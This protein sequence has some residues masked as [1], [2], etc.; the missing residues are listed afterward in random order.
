M[1]FSKH[2][3]FTGSESSMSKQSATGRKA[4][5]R[6]RRSYFLKNQ[7]LA[8]ANIALQ[9]DV[10][11]LQKSLARSRQQLPSQLKSPRSQVAQLTQGQFISNDIREKLMDNAVLEAELQ[12]VTEGF[13]E[14]NTPGKKIFCKFLSGRILKRYKRLGRFKKI[15]PLK[16]MKTARKFYGDRKSISDYVKKSTSSNSMKIRESVQAF[17]LSETASHYSAGKKCFVKVD[18][19]KVQKRYLNDS[20]KE[21]HKIYLTTSPLRISYSTFCRLTPPSVETPKLS[22]RD[23]CLCTKCVN[24]DLLAQA[25]NFYKI[26]KEASGKEVI[27]SI[28]CD[29]NKEDCLFKNCV[30]CREKSL[31]YKQFNPTDE[32]QF[33]EWITEKETRISSKTKKQINVKVTKKVERTAFIHEVVSKMETLLEKQLSHQGRIIHQRDIWKSKAENMTEEDLLIVMDW[34]ENYILRCHAEIQSA[35]FGSS[36]R[37][38]SLHTGMVQKSDGTK[39]TFCTVSKSKRHDP[40][41]IVAHIK[42]ILER[43]ITDKTIHLHVKSDGPS[44]QYRSRNM[45]FSICKNISAIAPQIKYITWNY[46]ESGHGKSEADAV[47]GATKRALDSALAHGKD[48]N[49]M[50]TAMD[51]LRSK[52]QATHFE[53][54]PEAVIEESKKIPE[55]EPFQGTQQVHQVLWTSEKPEELTMRSISCYSCVSDCPHFLLGKWMLKP[56]QTKKR[57]AP[58]KSNVNPTNSTKKKSRAP[59]AKKTPRKK[60][61][62]KKTSANKENEPLHSQPKQ[63]ASSTIK[64][65]RNGDGPRRSQPKNME[66]STR[67]L[68]CRNV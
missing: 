43:H 26:I 16:S 58:S 51:I 63:A 60:K 28:C 66:P 2:F 53:L 39:E 25:L 8:N 17:Y 21:L 22:G 48:V 1:S 59:A 52:C 30:T 50:E 18:G 34:S 64:E 32:M 45:F 5:R 14:G 20:R 40:V 61:S 31:I 49:T 42:P 15:L 13:G 9:R 36:N 55:V 44:T 4:V 46:S 56:K 41:A 10:W 62:T 47:G 29:K 6:D 35:H 3:I 27:S 67:V 23:T 68:R 7:R 37:E 19:Q 54:I 38:I 24:F 57:K 12:D 33:K 11:R 65:K